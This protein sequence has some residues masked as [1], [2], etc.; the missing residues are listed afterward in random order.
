[1]HKRIASSLRFYEFIQKLKFKCNEYNVNL[2]LVDESYTS[3]ICSFCKQI[4]TI[5]NNRQ[6]NCSCNLSLDRDINGCINILLKSLN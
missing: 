4:T 5:N 6:L 2:T 1:M 3:K